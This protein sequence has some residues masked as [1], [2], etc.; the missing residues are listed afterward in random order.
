MVGG[1][2]E[3]AASAAD[4]LHVSDGATSYSRG[5]LNELA[6]RTIDALR[7]RG[8]GVG[9]PVAILAGNRADWAVLV[10][11]TSLG[12]MPPVPVNTHL[13]LDE[14]AYILANAQARTLFVDR[15]HA[16]LGREAAAVAGLAPG[17]VVDIDE[18][19]WADELAAASPAE[20]PDDTP[21][22]GTIYYTSGTTGRPKGTRMNMVPTGVPVDRYLDGV[23]PLWELMEIG[24]HT[25]HLVTGP[26]YHAAPQTMF[27]S[28]LDAGATVHVMPRFEPEE[29]LRLVEA[30]RIDTL[31]VVPTM[32]VRWLRLPDEVRDRHDVTS[33]RAV[34]HTAAP[35]PP[36]VK[37]AIIDRWGP[38]L[39]EGYGASE[40]GAL[41]SISAE[42]WLERP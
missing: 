29:A 38:V 42:E 12:G 18:P 31:I 10:S 23:G 14:T 21:F 20:P 30:H 32:L 36:E 33:L 5:R 22:A 3:L 24:P 40:I 19:S 34:T 15:A 4:S 27:A 8:V 26:L 13:T 16:G 35:C 41:T 6:N 25:R 1:L 17:Q 28:C 37:R 11:A 7:R 39:R 2:R 9:D